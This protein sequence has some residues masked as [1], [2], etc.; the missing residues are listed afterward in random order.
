MTT[1]TKKPLTKKAAAQRANKI[2]KLLAEY[3]G[4]LDELVDAHIRVRELKDRQSEIAKAVMNVGG[5]GAIFEYRGQYL[6]AV[7]KGH[8]HVGMKLVNHKIPEKVG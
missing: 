8:G 2:A 5:K 3:D 7:N 6:T 4:V 1:R